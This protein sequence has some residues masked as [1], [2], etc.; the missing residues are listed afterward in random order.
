MLEE[1]IWSVKLLGYYFGTKT[2][3]LSGAINIYGVLAE[4]PQVKFT[5][6]F[7]NAEEDEVSIKF[8]IDKPFIY[9]N[10]SILSL[11]NLR[12][13]RVEINRNNS[14][15]QTVYVVDTTI[16]E[17]VLDVKCKIFY[18]KDKPFTK[19]LD[20]DDFTDLDIENHN[21]IAALT[22]GEDATD[23]GSND[24]VVD[25]PFI[26]TDKIFVSQV[27][28][29]FKALKGDLKL[30]NKGKSSFYPIQF[31]GIPYLII[32]WMDAKNIDCLDI[33]C[34]PTYRAK[35]NCIFKDVHNNLSL[36]R[37]LS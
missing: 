7:F 14:V 6:N 12:G 29:F 3:T 19:R 32:S 10:Q 22:Y 16:T 24:I 5:T 33:H 11:G 31:N 17:N 30:Y 23:A 37:Y 25:A 26:D 15:R 13:Q 34:P 4:D 20:K 2:Y 35:A 28:E 21:D 36:G 18:F 27:V 8:R 1:G 9:L